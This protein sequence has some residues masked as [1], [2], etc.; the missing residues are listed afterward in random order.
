[1]LAKLYFQ[2]RLPEYGYRQ[3][4]KHQKLN[5]NFFTESH[6]HIAVFLVYDSDCFLPKLKKTILFMDIFHSKQLERQ[7]G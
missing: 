4:C 3:D 7:S 5:F 6:I 2:T 1:M